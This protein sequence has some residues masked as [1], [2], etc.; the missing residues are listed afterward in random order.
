MSFLTP[1]SALLG[2]AV[3]VPLLVLLYFLK[4]RRQ[5]LRMASTI[6]WR[7][8]TE[9]LQANVPFQRLRWS[10]LLLLQMLLVAVLLA[11]L[12]RPVVQT[13][14]GAAS[15]I[16]LLIDRSASMNAP[17]GVGATHRSRLD[18]ARDA[19]RETVD[20][21]VRRSEPAQ[22]MV[23]AFAATPRLYSGFESNR[24]LL[25]DAIDAIEPTDEQA[26]LEAALDLAAA[27][28]VRDETV[29]EAPP[30]IVLFSDGDLGTGA[31][32]DRGFLLPAGA[33][34]FVGIGPPEGTPVDN[35]GIAAFS[36]RRDYRQPGRLLVFARLVNAGPATIDTAVTL[37]VDGRPVQTT[38]L[39]VPGATAQGPG[40]AAYTASQDIP[41]SAV[42]S[43]T[44]G[45]PD[46]LAADNTAALVIRPPASPRIGVVHAGSAPDRFLVGLLEAMEPQRLVVIPAG[47]GDGEL[48][49]PWSAGDLDLVIFDRVA[50]PVLPP[51]PTL[52]LGAVPPGLRLHEPPATG[53]V[54]V[55][56]W[57]RLHPVMRH[58][59]LDGL[60]YAGFGGYDLPEQWTALAFGPGGPVIA[61]RD[62]GP[63]R[64]V[65]VGFEMTRSNW[66]MDVS[67]TV[68]LQ[69]VLDH[70]LGAAGE[71]AISFRP[72]DAITARAGPDVTEM[73]IEGPL[74]ATV[75]VTPGGLA[76]LPPLR[77]VGLYRV[78][79]ARPPMDR[80]AVSMLSDQESDIRPR[81]SVRVNAIETTAGAVGD[82]APLELWPALVAIALALLLA[83]WVVY[84]MRI[85]G[86]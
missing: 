48:E 54:R 82:A 76:T 65:A 40:E 35:L 60:V 73:V 68:F 42:L 11:A 25:L 2:A 6:L 77:R 50:P 22:L 69:N 38:S 18:A 9:D 29:D 52:T 34:R 70:L 71:A 33:L 44:C 81:R 30:D 49:L 8:A 20:R 45:R 27:F 37:R 12:A 39:T 41:S 80:V 19:A 59:S 66:P 46:D 72:G 84:C 85:R 61:S 5:T 31:Q 3:A 56:S 64:H 63:D 24:R 86:T 14:R 55:L 51:L 62:G 28:A 53:A 17:A 10:L 1:W 21:L 15:R 74:T 4:L 43:L 58:V 47:T 26:D 32:S 57:D 23:V 7:T 79:G 67:I 83:E 78:R 16:I 36:A 13:G 75:E